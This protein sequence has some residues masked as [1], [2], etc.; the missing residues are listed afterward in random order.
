MPI[1]QFLCVLSFK[2]ELF[3]L[4]LAL[5][6]AR[7]QFVIIDSKVSL[8]QLALPELDEF[9]QIISNKGLVVS[10]YELITPVSFTKHKLFALL[11]IILT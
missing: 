9:L 2:F 7:R 6:N 1:S 8:Q 11:H 3:R 4:A 5:S 10:P